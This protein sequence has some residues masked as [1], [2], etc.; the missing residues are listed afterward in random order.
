ME[1]GLRKSFK[2]VAPGRSLRRRVAYSLAIVRL[3]LVPVIFL[4]VYYLFGMRSIV[5]RIVPNL[6]NLPPANDPTRFAAAVRT[7]ARASAQALVKASPL[8]AELVPDRRVV[9]V[10]AAYDLKTGVVEFLD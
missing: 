5:D 9:V 7:N 1:L 10:A 4:A 2:I 6:T 3:I 8:L